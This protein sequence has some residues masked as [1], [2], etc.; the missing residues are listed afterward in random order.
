MVKSLDL[1]V[2]ESHNLTGSICKTF[3]HNFVPLMLSIL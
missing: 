3:K 1:L 2:G